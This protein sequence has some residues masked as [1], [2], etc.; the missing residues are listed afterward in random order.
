M[1]P[2]SFDGRGI[3]TSESA[4]T[5][6]QMHIEQLQ[7]ENHKGLIQHYMVRIA[8]SSE[9]E[10]EDA[11]MAWRPGERATFAGDPDHT[12]WALVKWDRKNHKWSAPMGTIKEWQEELLLLPA[13]TES[14][15]KVTLLGR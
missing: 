12:R 4:Q 7:E 13:P 11:L 9:E 2:S 3:D 15:L 8:S 6:E 5:C 1:A 14:D 10:F